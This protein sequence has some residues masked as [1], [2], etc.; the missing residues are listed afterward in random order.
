MPPSPLSRFLPLLLA[1]LLPCTATAVPDAAAF[2]QTPHIDHVEL[3]PKGGYVAVLTALPGGTAGLV[4]YETAD[5]SKFS[6]VIKTSVNE[7]ITSVHWVNEQR[8]GFTV[9][10]L[11]KEFEGNLDEMAAD[12]DGSNLIH[13]ISGSWQHHQEVTGSF[14][15]SRRLSADY[16]YYGAT[17]DGSDDILVEHYVWN[18][19]DKTPDHSRLQ[20]LNT[21]NYQLSSTF[22]GK[23]PDAVRGWLT[24]AR[25]V[26]RV[27]TS[28]RQGRCII[29]Y[30]KDSD[31]SWAELSNNNC[32]QDERFAPLFL[33]GD[34]TLYV[35]ASHKGYGALF[36][37]DL[38]KMKLASQPFIAVPGFDFSGS[39]EIDGPSGKLLG[40]HMQTDAGTTYWLD[41]VLKADQ[42]RIDAALPATTNTIHCP[43]SCLSS[44]VLLV[45]SSSDRQ[46]DQY[47]LYTRASGKLAGLGSQHPDID[48]QQMGMRDLHRY[49]ARDGREIPAYVT[50]PPG[51]ADG[52]RPAIVLTH[53]GPYVR[54][55]YWD[56]DA[57][58]QFLASRG[59]V[60]IQ[61]DYRGSTGYGYDHFKAGWKQWGASMQ[62]D[63]ADA[64]L[65]ATK[66]GWAD[67]KRIAIMGASY[68]GYAT[69]MGLIKH[70]EIY[71]C[72][73]EWAG[74]T[75]INLM[76]TSS[77]SDVS[78]ESLNYSMRTLVGDPQQDAALF[79]TNSPLLRAAELKQPL[80]MAHGLEDRRVPLEHA[81]RFRSAVKQ[82]NDNVSYIVY[83]N[84]GH[85]WRH[86]DN[87]IDFWKK[88]EAFLER[89]L[90][91]AK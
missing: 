85:G 63:L 81:D 10:N 15:K 35:Q 91:Q 61:P 2:F 45:V 60:V 20:R 53:G 68:G 34:E 11:R 21:R 6:I 22:E 88:T 83:N 76:F 48:P 37:Y 51:K 5:P 23:Q 3:S 27:A 62:D 25:D 82:H 26:P 46:P 24:D 74:V 28:V 73:V 7:N 8:I 31:T 72:G 36:R 65:W 19:V 89:N 38:R 4:V 18:G 58:A 12:R 78:E 64:A 80:L 50:L 47:I 13:L 14:I 86:E 30:R 71:R 1:A 42:A 41:P 32:L 49:K 39:P 16:A 66:Q 70:P 77:Q 67:P 75:D 17:H 69:L 59:Y 79:R 9:K 57:E 55:G 90:R 52:P 84:E 56:W 87:R 54:G 44:P 33:D 40:I 43:Q 29:S